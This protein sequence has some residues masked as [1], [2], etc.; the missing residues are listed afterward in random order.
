MI[1]KY[2]VLGFVFIP[3]VEIYLLVKVGG[4]IGAWPTVFLVVAMGIAGATLM[5]WQG[6]ATL[7]RVRET[8]ARGQ[9]PAVELVEGAAILVGGVL[10]LTPGFFTDVLGI[11]C[12][13]PPLR[14]RM[15]LEFLRRSMVI[16][17][18]HPEPRGFR[19]SGTIEGQFRRED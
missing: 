5:R 11:L 10:L 14:R 8:M 2:L 16:H 6:T 18:V 19:D 4:L 7:A 13:I 1:L 17:T 12:L 3:L 9:V 15:A